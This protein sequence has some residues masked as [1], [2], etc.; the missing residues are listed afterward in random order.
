MPVQSRKN[1]FLG[2]NPHLH[3]DLQEH[4]DWEEFHGQQI[5]YLTRELKAQLLPMGYTAHSEQSLQIWYEEKAAGKPV[6]DVTIYDPY[7]ERATL[8]RRS[9]G[10]DVAELV[11]AIPDVFQ[12]I[13][14]YEFRAIAIYQLVPRREDRGE[15]VAWIELLSPSNKTGGE[16]SPYRVKRRSL[17]ESGVVFVELDY[18]HETPPA[19]DVVPPYPESGSYPYRITIFEPRPDAYQGKA[20]IRQFRVD[21]PIP[22]MKIPLSGDDVLEFD[23]NAPYQ[24]TFEEMLYGLE[25]GLVDYSQLPVNF[26]RYSPDDQARVVNRMLAVLEAKQNG[27]DLEAGTTEVQALSLPDAL[28]QFQRLQSE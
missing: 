5:T 28:A 6:S 11:I 8:T 22:S 3:S 21:E 19:V 24:R 16:G 4:G 18:L 2:I 12:K 13:E 26:D 15:P 20:R 27:E 23:F 25:P 10:T 9:L 7:P 14:P 1:K 17:V